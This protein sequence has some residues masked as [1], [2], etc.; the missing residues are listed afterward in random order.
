MV[1][2]QTGVATLTTIKMPFARL[3]TTKGCRGR[4]EQPAVVLASC[5]TSSRDEKSR[6]PTVVE[7]QMAAVTKATVS[8]DVQLVDR[9]APNRTQSGV[10]AEWSFVLVKAWPLYAKE[11]TES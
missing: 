2:A 8:A 7:A 10:E 1:A 5:G 6:V 11:V 9:S 3:P 4:A